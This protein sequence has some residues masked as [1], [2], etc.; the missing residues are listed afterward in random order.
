MKADTPKRAAFLQQYIKSYKTT[1][2]M[3]PKSY[4]KEKRGL[5]A[6]LNVF[7]ET[8]IHYRIMGGV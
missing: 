8:Q 2:P 5:F 7:G 6:T 4:I 1:F 3:P